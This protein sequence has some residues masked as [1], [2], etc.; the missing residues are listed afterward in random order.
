MVR[1]GNHVDEAGDRSK[2][3][4][5]DG[6]RTAWL[7]TYVKE[8]SGGQWWWAETREHVVCA[9]SED[10]FEGDATTDCE[11]GAQALIRWAHVNAVTRTKVAGSSSINGMEAVVI[12]VPEVHR[13]DRARD[14]N[15]S[16]AASLEGESAEDRLDTGI[17]FVIA[18]QSIGEGE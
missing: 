8:L 16:G 2:R 3:C 1:T 15:G 5:I 4:V 18:H 10:G 17:P 6:D 7:G 9:R 12:G 11:V 14:G 13:P